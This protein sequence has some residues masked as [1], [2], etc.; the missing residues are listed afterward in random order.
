MRTTGSGRALSACCASA[1]CAS[2]E[3]CN[4]PGQEG[5]CTAV[6]TPTATATESPGTTPVPTRTAGEIVCPDEGC[7]CAGDCN[8]D[9]AAT[10]DEL[11][12]LV[13]IALGAATVDACPTADVGPDGQITIDQVLAAA[14]NVLNGCP[15]PTAGMQ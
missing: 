3:S 7:P 14:D 1:A 10:I 11:V 4:L 15:T 8:D 9:H 6:S 12:L 5:H 13:N 2:G